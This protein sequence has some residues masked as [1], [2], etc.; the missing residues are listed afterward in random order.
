[1]LSFGACLVMAWIEMLSNQ[2]RWNP[3][4]KLTAP[5]VLKDAGT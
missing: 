1:M 4:P 5:A 2:A 3:E